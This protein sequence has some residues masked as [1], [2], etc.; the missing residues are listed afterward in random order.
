MSCAHRLARLGALTGGLCGLAFIGVLGAAPAFAADPFLYVGGPGCS[1]SGPGTQAQPFCTIK[2]GATVATAG[3][4]V[5]VASGTYSESVTVGKSGTAGSPITLRPAAGATVTVTG[6][7][8]GFVVSGKSYVTISGFNVTE[9]TSYGISVKSSSH[10]VISGNTV[11]GAGTPVSGGIAAGIYLKSTTDSTVKGNFTHHNSDHGIYLAADTSETTVQGNESSFNAN[12][13][14]RNANG[15]DVIGPD[16]TIIGNVLHDNEDSGLQFYPGAD[17]SLATLNVTYNNGDHGIDN[18]NVTGGRLI[19]NTVYHNCTSGI[20][21]EGTS[22]NYV[23]VNNIAVDNAV[24]P[25]YNGIACNRRA[26][27]IGIWD[28]APATTVVD[29]NLVYLSKPGTMY[30]FGSSFASL[31]AMRAATGQ[32]QHGLQAN[33]LFVNAA[34]GNLRLSQGSPAIDSADSGVDGEQPVD[35]NGTPRRDDPAVPNTG[36]GPRPYDDRGAYEF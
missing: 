32:E 6:G 31:A 33:P 25:A 27:N 29:S 3:Q 4:T 34:G 24:Y 20:N 13:Y 12:E 16:N 2:K 28:S 17:N 15:I 8:S 9:T 14:R 18:L 30:V 21:V 7:T 22:G 26:G 23:V 11:S 36:I 5:V 35:I 19:G 1:D 10:I